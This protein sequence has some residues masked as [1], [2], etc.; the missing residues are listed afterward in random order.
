VWPR[1]G[2]ARSWPS[3]TATRRFREGANVSMLVPVRSRASHRSTCAAVDFAWTDAARTLVSVNLPQYLSSGEWFL[4]LR[5]S[6]APIL[7]FRFCSR[8]RAPQRTRVV[9]QSRRLLLPMTV[10]IQVLEFCEALQR[11]AIPCRFLVGGVSTETDPNA[12]THRRTCTIRRVR[13]SARMPDA[14]TQSLALL[15][16]HSTSGRQDRNRGRVCQ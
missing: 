15:R 11:G 5:T 13:S 9:Y 14:W 4:V 10:N 7:S 6:E 3:K 12:V 16:A 2:S 1:V 8:F